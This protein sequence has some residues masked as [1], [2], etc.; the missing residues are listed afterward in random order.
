[1]SRQL[2]HLLM[3][4]RATVPFLNAPLSPAGGLQIPVEQ[5]IW[6]TTE[7]QVTT[8][9]S[10]EQQNGTHRPVEMDGDGDG[11]KKIA[12]PVQE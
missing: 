4:A 6:T 12:R 1:M 8:R 3:I 5:A 9:R 2:M 7:M 10:I 11:D